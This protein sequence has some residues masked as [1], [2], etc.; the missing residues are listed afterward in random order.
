MTKTNRSWPRRVL[1]RCAIIALGLFGF[2]K[3]FGVFFVV[4]WVIGKVFGSADLVWWSQSLGVGIFC[5]SAGLLLIFSWFLPEVDHERIRAERADR[6]AALIR[7]ME[8]P[9][10]WSNGPALACDRPALLASFRAEGFDPG[11][12]MTTANFLAQK[13]VEKEMK[14]QGF[15]IHD[16]QSAHVKTAARAMLDAR[17]D[18]LIA[19]AKARLIDYPN[20]L[21]RR[22]K[23]VGG[24]E[25]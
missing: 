6:Y 5:V 23:A 10:H 15:T 24:T 25:R 19:E 3:I 7:A 11:E 17:T 22:S 18:A 9:D 8:Q 14:D 4:L 20:K 2:W 1:E 12:V 21:S 13:A 16:I